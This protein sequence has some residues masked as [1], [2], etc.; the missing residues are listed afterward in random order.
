MTAVAELAPPVTA[1]DAETALA[2]H[3]ARMAVVEEFR[4]AGI[5]TLGL[6]DGMAADFS[7]DATLRG[8][9][10]SAPGENRI[11][12][13]PQATEETSPF[14]NL[15]RWQVWRMERQNRA[16]NRH[17]ERDA[18]Q[19]EQAQSA[20]RLRHE[21]RKRRASAPVGYSALANLSAVM[22]RFA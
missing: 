17:D 18:L 13:Q 10:Q 2:R 19:A 16:T 3:E 20:E 7:F 6:L 9:Q 21:E 5:D 8:P 12:P 1:L 4:A 22:P 11:A 14:A 15:S